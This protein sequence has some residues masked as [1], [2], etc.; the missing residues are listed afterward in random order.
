MQTLTYKY[1]VYK[2]NRNHERRLQEWLRTAAWVY[3]HAIALHKRYYR[4]YHK[5]ISMYR[6]Q[7]HLL[8]LRKSSY[9]QW[10]VIGS[11]SVQQICERINNGYKNFSIERPSIFQHLRIGENIAQSRSNRQDILLTEMFSL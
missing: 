9:S 3:N 1:K 11:Q 5:S 8:K 2:Q 10:K 6:L 7:S 4:I